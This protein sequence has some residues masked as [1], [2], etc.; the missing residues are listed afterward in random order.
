MS[1]VG[2]VALL[3]ELQLEYERRR[4]QENQS[5]L[6]SAISKTEELFDLSQVSAANENQAKVVS[7]ASLAD[8]LNRLPPIDVDEIPDL[9]DVEESNRSEVVTPGGDDLPVVRTTG[10][11]RYTL[12]GT[13]ITI[14][15]IEEGP[16]LGDFLFS[17]DTVSQLPSWR[18]E[19]DDLP[20]NDDVVIRDW[21][22]VEEDF[23][24]HLV[25]RSLIDALPDGFDRDFLGAPLWKVIADVFILGAV[26]L[27]AWLWQ[28]WVGRRG[29]AGAPSGYL[30][31]LTTPII[32]MILITAARRF[33]NEQVN[34]TGDI[35]TV[36]NLMVTFVIWASLA[37]AFWIATKLVVEWIIATPAI[38]NESVDAHLLRLLGKV[39]SAVGAFSI[40]WVGLS[41]LGVSTL[42]LG[43]GAG[44]IGLAAALAAT[45]TLENLLGGIT[46]YADKPFAVDDKIRVGDDFGTVE[47]IGPRST[48]IRRLDDTQVI[49]PNAD[50]SRAKVTNFSERNHILFEHLIGVRY[51][52]TVD[53]LRTI[54]DAIDAR[55]REHPMVLDETDFPRVR[56]FG[57]GASSIDIE[58]RAGVD[59]H[60]YDE[61]TEIQ[62]ELLLL[63]YDVVETSGS[64][65]AF[66]SSTTYLAHDVGLPDPRP[67]ALVDGAVIRTSTGENGPTGDGVDD[68]E[69]LAD[70]DART[71][72]PA[73]ASR[74]G[75]E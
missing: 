53:Q 27:A 55:L 26:G 24:G 6:S 39:V 73:T 60:E 46:V 40:A 52:T 42:S 15:L 11:T 1:F 64:G 49:L 28:R 61:F 16:R 71:V 75:S 18:E 20:V 45:T 38:S 8:I 74:S 51:E 33:M 67:S 37:W 3:E 43:L 54:V 41:R 47:E 31:R 30:Y 23:T 4:T 29:V 22:Q 35:A 25:P 2:Q 14:K 10:I 34:H 50:V 44:V 70:R 65:F 68:A 69:Q 12:P 21:V 7:F 9:D 48:R 13:E 57:F 63:I 66:P 58:V 5:A 17:A 62:Q 32:T 19:V 56:V 36:V 59:T 72:G